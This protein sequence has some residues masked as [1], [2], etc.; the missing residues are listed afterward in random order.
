MTIEVTGPG[1][2]HIVRFRVK[3]ST[4]IEKVR[5]SYGRSIEISP[6][7]LIF[8][9]SGSGRRISDDTIAHHQIEDGDVIDA[10]EAQSGC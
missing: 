7:E 9:H 8:I 6:S 2:S 1:E 5:Q 4:Q 10:H 3:P